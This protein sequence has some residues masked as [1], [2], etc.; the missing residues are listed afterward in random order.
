MNIDT[1]SIE[2]KEIVRRFWMPRLLQKARET[3]PPQP[4]PPPPAMS[5]QNQTIPLPM[6]SVSQCS[7]IGTVPIP[8]QTIPWQGGSYCVMNETVQ[9]SSCLSSSSSESSNIPEGSQFQSL[10]NNDMS[11]FM[12]DGY[13]VNNN[14][15]DMETFNLDPTLTSEVMEGNWMNSMWGIDELWQFRNLQQS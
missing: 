7:Q 9:N 10:D 13:Y 2:F 3:T 11:S 15:Y 14:A 1:N 6:Y 12:Y 5:I 4:P 8:T